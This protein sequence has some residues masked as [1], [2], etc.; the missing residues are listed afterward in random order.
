MKLYDLGK[1]CKT[2]NFFQCDM[3][4]IQTCIHSAKI[5]YFDSSRCGGFK[6]TIIKHAGRLM[7]SDTLNIYNIL[8]ILCAHLYII[9]PL[10]TEHTPGCTRCKRMIPLEALLYAYTSSDLKTV[11]TSPTRRPPERHH[12]LQHFN[13]Q[14]C[15]NK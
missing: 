6:I 1:L 9:H 12:C 7:R 5:Q 13:W 3:Y 15:P 8:S 11:V 10:C 14:Y 2:L 4:R